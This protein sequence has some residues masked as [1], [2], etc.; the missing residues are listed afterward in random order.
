MVTPPHLVPHKGGA[1]PLEW[2][3]PVAGWDGAVPAVFQEPCSPAHTFLTVRDARHAAEARESPAI[4]EEAAP[5]AL[6]VSSYFFYFPFLYL[7]ILILIVE[8][9]IVLN[10]PVVYNL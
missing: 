8:L 6:Q 4:T 1:T 7:S 10:T 2:W 5:S 3:I 9:D